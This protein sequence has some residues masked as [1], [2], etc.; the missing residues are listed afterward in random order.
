MGPPDEPLQRRKKRFILW[1]TRKP[2]LN[3]RNLYDRNSRY[4]SSQLFTLGFFTFLWWRLNRTHILL[5]SKKWTR[6][7]E[8]QKSKRWEEFINPKTHFFYNKWIP[9]R[10]KRRLRILIFNIKLL[11]QQLYHHLI[12]N[13]RSIIQSFAK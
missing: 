3:D 8:R 13:P 2:L 10:T 12:L 6:L 5:S 4:S 7:W 1:G 9:E 11:E